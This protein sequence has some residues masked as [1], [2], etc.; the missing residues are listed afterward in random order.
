MYTILD[1]PLEDPIHRSAEQSGGEDATLSD[2][3]YRR[4]Y[5]GVDAVDPDPGCGAC[6]KVLDEVK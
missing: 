6:V 3:R 2:T 4:G 5:V 1:Q